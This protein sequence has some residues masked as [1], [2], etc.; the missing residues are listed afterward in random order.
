MQHTVVVGSLGV[1][2]TGAVIQNLL[3]AA[4]RVG[5]EHENLAIMRVRGLEQL[6]S[7]TLGLAERLLVAEDDLFGVLMQLAEGDKTAPFL[8]DFGS[9]NLESRSE[10]HTSE[11][12]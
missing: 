5:I 9:G 6:Q 7:V 1:G 12:Q 11:L 8:D 3:D 10:E 4:G 2:G